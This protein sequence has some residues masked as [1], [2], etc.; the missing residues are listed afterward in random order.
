MSDVITT[1]H[2]KI[3]RIILVQN[4]LYFILRFRF[5]TFHKKSE[6]YFHGT[7]EHKSAMCLSV[8]K[9]GISK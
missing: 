6:Y 8:A 3:I 2:T 7:V 9:S 5:I 1:Y 4:A